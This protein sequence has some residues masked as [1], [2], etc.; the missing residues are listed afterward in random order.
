MVNR[1][2]IK[3]QIDTLSDEAVL[4]IDRIIN[5]EN[6]ARNITEYN[7]KTQKAIKASHAKPHK[8]EKFKTTEAL[9]KDLGI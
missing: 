8:S 7:K 1:E 3:L 2:Y 6:S 4:K 9:F 5:S